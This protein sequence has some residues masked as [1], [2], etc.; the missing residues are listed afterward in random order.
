LK[1]VAEQ[2]EKWPAPEKPEGKPLGIFDTPEDEQV[3]A[4]QPWRD[5][6]DAIQKRKEERKR[7]KPQSR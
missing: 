2:V 3:P 4:W 5:R 6:W 7:K 1:K